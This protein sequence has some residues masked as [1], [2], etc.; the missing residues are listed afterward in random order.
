MSTETLLLIVVI[1]LLAGALPLWPHSR[2]WG[3]APSGVLTLLLVIFVI[4]ALAGDR[5]LFRSHSGHSLQDAAQNAGDDIKEA[6]HDVASSV[7]RAVN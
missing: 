2:S 1:I 4:W 6:G 3:Y 7:R 5:P